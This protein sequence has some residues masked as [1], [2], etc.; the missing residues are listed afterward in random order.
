MTNWRFI[1]EFINGKW[2]GDVSTWLR[3]VPLFPQSVE[4]EANSHRA[5]ETLHACRWVKIRNGNRTEWS[6]IR[7]V[8]VSITKS[9]IVIGSPRA[10]LP[11]NWRVITW[12]SNHRCPIWT[13]CNWIPEIGYPRD[14]H[15]YYVCFNAWLPSQ[16][17]LQFSKLRKSATDVFAEKK[18]P[19]D[20][21]IPKFVMNTIN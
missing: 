3:A 6:P 19:E 18:F 15:V 7:S 21:L 17:F 12:V 5:P 9:S 13:F 20:T 4:Q 11:R 2:T 16:C 10:Y 1:F 14:F 8:I